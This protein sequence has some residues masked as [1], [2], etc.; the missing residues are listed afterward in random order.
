MLRPEPLDFVIVAL[1]A[2]LLFGANRLPETARGIRRA[3][4][5]FKAGVSGRDEIPALPTPVCHN[6]RQ[7]LQ[8]GAKFCPDCG[9]QQ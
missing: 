6:C 9:S 1:V 7:P 4:F 3:L 8:P 5:E 2:L